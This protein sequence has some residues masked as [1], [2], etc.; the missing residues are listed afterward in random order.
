MFE[1]IF[2]MLKFIPTPSTA[3]L[4]MKEHLTIILMKLTR[5][6]NIFIKQMKQTLST[7]YLVLKISI[8]KEVILILLTIELIL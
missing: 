2:Q 6:R 8:Q 7:S 3:Q 5:L 4:L 1:I